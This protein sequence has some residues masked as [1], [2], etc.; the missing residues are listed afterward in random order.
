MLKKIFLADKIY[1]IFVS[2]T[3]ICNMKCPYCLVRESNDK[4]TIRDQE[5]LWSRLNAFIDKFQTRIVKDT[6]VSLTGG[7]ALWNIDFTCKLL[8]RFMEPPFENPN[9]TIFTN[10]ELLDDQERIKRILDINPNVGLT[11]GFDNSQKSIF[12][13][14]EKHLDTIRDF[15]SRGRVFSIFVIDGKNGLEDI[16]ENV[17]RIIEVTGATPRVEYDVFKLAELNEDGITEKIKEQLIKC[18]YKHF[19]QGT[20]DVTQCGLFYFSPDGISKACSGEIDSSYGYNKAKEFR[21]ANCKTC[22]YY[23]YCRNCEVKIAQ[24]G[25]SNICRYMKAITEVARNANN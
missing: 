25:G 11:L 19:Q 9:V 24:Y 8:K 22:D 17:G 4:Y 20:G 3:R 1:E 2:S 5:L 21:E 7:E 13:L 6:K 14:S 18:N 16:A 15:A 10:C 23:Q 12:R